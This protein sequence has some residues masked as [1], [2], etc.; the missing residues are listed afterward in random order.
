MAVKPNTAAAGFTP[1]WRPAKVTQAQRT[2]AA[3]K[4]HDEWTRKNLSKF[5]PTKTVPKGSGSSPAPVAQKAAAAASTAGTTQADLLANYNLARAKILQGMAP[6][7]QDIYQQANQ[8]LVSNVGGLTGDLQ[9]QLYEAG[10]GKAAA[11]GTEDPRIAASYNIGSAPNAAYYLGAA[12]PGDTL[13]KQGAAFGAAAAFA[14]ERALTEGQY[15]IQAAVN[16]AKIT[17]ANLTKVSASTSKMLGY[18]ADAY[19]NPVLGKNGKPVPLPKPQMTPYQQAS[20]GI[21]ANEIDYRRYQSD[22]NYKLAADKANATD[23]RYYNGL[24]F[25][26]AQAAEAARQKHAGTDYTASA[27]AGHLVG[28]DGKPQTDKNGRLIKFDSKTSSA[29]TPSLTQKAALDKTVQSWYT[30]NTS[31]KTVKNPDGSYSALPV[32]RQGGKMNYQVALRRLIKS[33]GLKLQNAQDMLD[34]YYKLP[35]D[36]N[37][38]QGKTPAEIFKATRGR[39]LIDVQTRQELVRRWKIPKKLVEQASFDIAA[40]AHVYQ[41]YHQKGGK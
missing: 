14:P 16:K 19:G 35:D 15:A 38:L 20:L 11:F 23:A 33:Y 36:L 37:A 32:P 30:G 7:V 25:R 9:K 4:A 1:G 27:K 5:T 29:K 34:S 41:L 17:N 31:M 8:D 28:K 2:A 21:R 40:Y 10:G 6:Q 39:P 13:T 12:L 22:R 24:R 18:I 3:R 26:S